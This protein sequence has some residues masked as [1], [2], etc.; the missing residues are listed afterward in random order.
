MRA[1]GVDISRG[2]NS[3]H[4]RQNDFVVSS[5]SVFFRRRT[6]ASDAEVEEAQRYVVLHT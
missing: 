6:W 3:H 5:Q 1:T 4:R 2:V